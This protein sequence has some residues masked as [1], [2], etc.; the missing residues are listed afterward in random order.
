MRVLTSA[1]DKSG[2]S[3]LLMLI[4]NHEMLAEQERIAMLL[5]GQVPIK[6]LHI[7][8]MPLAES[9]AP[10]PLP[11]PCIELESEANLVSNG[12]KASV[13]LRASKASQEELARYVTTI[14]RTL[15]VSGLQNKERIFHVSL[16]NRVGLPDDSVAHVWEYPSNR[17]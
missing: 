7:T 13:Y 16:T 11:P 15:N 12:S 8:L 10:L 14:E 5:P 4:P 6:A 1:I 9:D 2:S 17:V 3:I